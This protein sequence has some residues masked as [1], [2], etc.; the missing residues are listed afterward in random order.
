MRGHPKLT[1]KL[2]DAFLLI[3]F[4]ASVYYNVRRWLEYGRWIKTGVY[5][6]MTVYERA[7]ADLNLQIN[8]YRTDVTLPFIYHPVVLRVLAQIDRVVHLR[9]CLISAYIASALFFIVQISRALAKELP[10]DQGEPVSALRVGTLML[11]CI[12]F[13]GALIT[14]ALTGNVT[15]YLHV[16]VIGL[17]VRYAYKKERW[18]AICLVAVVGIF[19]V[20]KPYFLSYVGLYFVLFAKKHV[21]PSVVLSGDIFL[22]IWSAGALHFP[23][24]YADFLA[25]LNKATLVTNDLGYS[26][27]GVFRAVTHSNQ[28]SIVAHCA[29]AAALLYVAVFRAP[30]AFGFSQSAVRRLLFALP[31]LVIANPRMKEYDFFAAV[32]C[33][34]LFAYLTSREY[35]KYVL[36]CGFI[37]SEVPMVAWLFQRRGI[38]PPDAVTTNDPWQLAALIA[39]IFSCLYVL[40]R[41]R[42]ETAKFEGVAEVDGGRYRD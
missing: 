24:E 39:V 34:L 3:S 14:S 32:V 29:L 19:S 17:A 6:D 5:W 11:A 40:S 30:R 23:V 9:L 41:A 1:P 8:P 4:A 26:F 28:F 36:V 42:P 7:V 25:A 31:F 18:A 13:T 12:S 35:F 33:G 27:F 22:A 15:P 37:V 20:V 10:A 38:S 2:V 16:A 21:L